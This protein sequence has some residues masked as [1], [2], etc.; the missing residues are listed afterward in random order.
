MSNR[1]DET[2]RKLRAAGRKAFMPFVTA[3]D[4]DLAAT[5]AIIREMA[6]RGASM[7]ELGLPYSDPVADGPTIQASYTRS[8]A[9]G[10][11]L[12]GIFA[13][14]REL[15]KDCQLPIAAMGSFSLAYRRG[16]DRF[17]AD[18][19]AAGIDGLILP[20]LSLEEY[21]AVAAAA[22]KHRLAHIMLIAPTTPWDRARRIAEHSTGFVYYISVTGLTGERTALPPEL[23]DRVAQL[24]TVTQTPICVGF[25]ISRPEQVRQVTDVADGAIVGSAIVR[26]V[27]ELSAGPREKL[28]AGV[29]QYVA[30]LTAALP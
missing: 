22:E 2:F 30:E 17:L 24:R 4:P 11:T 1:I 15:R 8:L 26:R 9:A 13:M 12:D 16:V 20:D 6:A 3:G 18:A 7:V 28:A 25:G 29:G 5:V 10:T 23:A 19:A 27:H 21:A 14:V